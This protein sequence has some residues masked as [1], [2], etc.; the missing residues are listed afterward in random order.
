MTRAAF[1][2]IASAACAGSAGSAG[3]AA[4]VAKKSIT[5]AS[6]TTSSVCFDPNQIM[7]FRTARYASQ[8]GAGANKSGVTKICLLRGTLAAACATTSG[9]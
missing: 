1:P 7:S 6:G 2:A 5:L 9:L 3:S 8:K 4:R